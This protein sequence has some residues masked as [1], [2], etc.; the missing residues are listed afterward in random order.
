MRILLNVVLS[1]MF[2]VGPGYAMSVVRTFEG[3]AAGDQ[4]GISVTALDF[5]GDFWTD[6]V[7]GAN[8]NDAGGNAA[9]RAYVFW[10]GDGDSVPDLTLTGPVSG[11]HFGWCVSGVGDVNGDSVD[12]LAV[13]AHFT[14]DVNTRSGRVYLFLGASEPDTVPDLVMADWVYDARLGYSISGGDF[15]GD[16]Y[17][18]IAAGAPNAYNRGIVRI[19]LGGDPPDSTCD[20]VLRGQADYDFFGS[21]VSLCGDLNDDGYDDLVVGAYGANHDEMYNIGRVYVYLG[22]AVPDTVV[23]FLL[24]GEAAN[25][26]FGNSV[27]AGGDFDL[28][29]I[30]DLCVG[31]YGCDVGDSSEVGKCYL[32]YGGAGFGGTAD[33]VLWSGATHNETFGISVSL[34]GRGVLPPYLAVGAEGNDDE[35]VNAG[36]TYAFRGPSPVPGSPDDEAA[37]G[38]AGALSGHVVGMLDGFTSSEPGVLVLSGAYNE[39][40]SGRARLYRIEAAAVPHGPEADPPAAVCGNPFIAGSRIEFRRASSVEDDAVVVTDS[41]GRVV[42]SRTGRGAGAFVWDGRTPAGE[43]VAPGVYYYALDPSSRRSKIVIVR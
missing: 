1:L 40:S 9:G 39:A 33:L 15:N 31:S 43:P 16:G 6:V 3:E 26:Y 11:G 14:S 8:T 37:G 32:F 13:G 42:F 29:G 5:N 17:A 4:F 34:Y 35:W 2:M 41:R 19:F 12:D 22:G 20:L 18:D 38:E 28:D 10:G 7:V 23:D 36:K 27:S 24:E 25:D 21:A 30:S